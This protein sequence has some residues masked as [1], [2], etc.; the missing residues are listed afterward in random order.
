MHFQILPPFYHLYLQIKEGRKEEYWQRETHSFLIGSPVTLTSHGQWRRECLGLSHRSSWK[1]TSPGQC[2][3]LV[4]MKAGIQAMEALNAESVVLHI[5]P[6][7][8]LLAK[9]RPKTSALAWSELGLGA[10]GKVYI[11]AQLAWAATPKE[12]KAPWTSL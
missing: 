12:R 1:D 8:W 4:L 5:S 11:C 9:L 3:S 7:W 6:Y 10:A 2:W